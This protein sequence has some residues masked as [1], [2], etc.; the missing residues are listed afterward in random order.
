MLRA[1]G[2]I[3]APAPPTRNVARM[4]APFPPSPSRGRVPMSDI[5]TRS[6][7]AWLID[8]ARDCV[9]PQDVLKKLADGLVAA[10]VPL[11]RAAVFVRT[12][13][14]LVARA[15]LRLARGRRRSRSASSNTRWSAPRATPTARSPTSTKRMWSCAGNWRAPTARSIFPSSRRSARK[16]SPIISAR[17]CASPS[18]ARSMSR[19]G[20]R[21]RRAASPTRISTP[22][23]RSW[24]RWRAS[25]RCAR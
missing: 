20:R 19:C 22:S 2:G 17:R 15:A 1:G 8:G 7:V 5:D 25:P 12:L 6:L 24:R 18:A 23:A 21:W 4:L 11:A 9:P 13:H 16:A 3:G 14:P 10:G